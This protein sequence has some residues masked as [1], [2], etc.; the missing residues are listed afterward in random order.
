M[1]TSILIT[2]SAAAVSTQL[3]HSLAHADM[4][5]V[6]I[7]TKPAQFEVDVTV[8]DLYLIIILLRV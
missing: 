8:M 2:L 5:V 7:D 1:N 3:L 6:C 4:Q